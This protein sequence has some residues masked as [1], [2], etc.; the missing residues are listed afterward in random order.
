MNKMPVALPVIKKIEFDKYGR[1]ENA[2]LEWQDRRFRLNIQDVIDVDDGGCILMPEDC[3][4]PF[5][6]AF[7]VWGDL[8]AFYP[9]TGASYPLVKGDEPNTQEV[10]WH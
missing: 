6:F 8:T 9:K 2:V 7:N 3:S 1:L 10:I 4:V 5:I